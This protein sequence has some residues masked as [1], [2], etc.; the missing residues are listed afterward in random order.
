MLSY[1]YPDSY[2][3]LKE[4]KGRS[5]IYGVLTIFFSFEKTQMAFMK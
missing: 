1:A 3:W 4:K 5:K 2:N